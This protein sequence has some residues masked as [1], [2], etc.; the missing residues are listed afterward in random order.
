MPNRGD[1]AVPI[2][3]QVEKPVIN[4]AHPGNGDH[5]VH[6]VPHQ[7]DSNHRPH[8]IEEDLPGTVHTCFLEK[9]VSTNSYCTKCSF[10]MVIY[11][12]IWAV[13]TAIVLTVAFT[14]PLFVC[15]KPDSCCSFG[16]SDVYCSKCSDNSCDFGSLCKQHPEWTQCC[17]NN[18]CH[19]VPQNYL[20]EVCDAGT[21]Q[22]AYLTA[23]TEYCS[24]N[25]AWVAVIVI[26]GFIGWVALLST[27]RYTLRACFPSCRCWLCLHI[28]DD[29]CE[30]F[31]CCCVNVPDYHFKE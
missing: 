12:S 28:W 18:L 26:F 20:F 30:D 8:Q 13:C 14:V 27:I 21:V 22:R 4:H 25:S 5:V 6:D 15:D 19:N 24:L 16:F 2:G 1:M 23:D 3:L 11:L 29:A 7:H 17:V 10:G 31:W 9:P